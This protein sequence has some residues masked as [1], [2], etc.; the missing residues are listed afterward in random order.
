MIFF[1]MIDLKQIRRALLYALCLFITLLLQNCALCH[2]RILGVK[3][4]IVPVTVAAIGLFTNGAWGGIFGLI[5]GVVCDAASSD[6]TV[7]FTVLFTAVGY[8]SALLAETLINRRFY[9]YMIVAALFLLMTALIQIVP[10][11]IY[12]GASLVPLLRTAL[13]QCAW[14]LP[15]AVP[16]YFACRGVWRR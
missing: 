14:S 8:V 10:V 16:A 12:K 6:T 7:L 15:F 11:W 3:P 9:S 5:A 2:L 4:M 1:D 13:L